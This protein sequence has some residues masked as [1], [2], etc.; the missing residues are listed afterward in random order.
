MQRLAIL[1]TRDIKN[2]K[3]RLQSQFGH[4]FRDDYVY[5]QNDKK[6]LFLT[7]R[8]ITLID[9]ESLHVDRLGLYVAEISDSEIR[10]SKEGS[11]LLVQDA[12]KHKLPVSN[13]L[14]LTKE[15]VLQYFLGADI[16]R[17]LGQESRFL[18]LFY[19]VDVLGCA[20][21]KEGK[22]LNFHPKVHRASVIV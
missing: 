17:D 13:T 8:D 18:I 1:N 10:L 20:K 21:Y 12:R 14:S 5:L 6:R 11:Q 16:A 2:I 7:T 19:G 15:E 22:I 9:L 3:E 4:A